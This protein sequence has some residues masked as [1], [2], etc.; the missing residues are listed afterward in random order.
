[1]LM[2][3]V[4]ITGSSPARADMQLASLPGIK[5]DHVLVEKAKR[6]LSLWAHGNLLRSYRIALGPR[7]RGHKRHEGDGRTPE[8]LYVL[9]WRNPDS[10][11]YKSI[12]ISY[13]DPADVAR[14]R[15]LGLDP[16]GQIMIHGLSPMKAPLGRDH[17][18]R[19]WT[20][21]CIAVTNREIEE[22]WTLV[23]DGTT[24]TIRP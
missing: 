14:A 19:D 16:G 20:Q 6:R 22:I 15:R 7:P 3:V 11:F 4:A 10:Q 5:A 9:D 12:H 18:W 1:M 24:I 21:G 13:P 8:G 23:Q 2:A 17:A